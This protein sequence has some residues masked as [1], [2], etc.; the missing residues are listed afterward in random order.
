[1]YLLLTNLCHL[2]LVI[3]KHHI[4]NVMAKDG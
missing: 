1:M 4:S 2:L 3:K